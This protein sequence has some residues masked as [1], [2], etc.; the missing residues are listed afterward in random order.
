MSK[1]HSWL[2]LK[3]IGQANY[4]PVPDSERIGKHNPTVSSK[5][6]WEVLANRSHTLPIWSPNICLFSLPHKIFSSSNPVMAPNWE[7]RTTVHSWQPLYQ[8]LRCLTSERVM[9]THHT[10]HQS[11]APHAHMPSVQW[12]DR[13]RI[14]T[15]NTSLWKGEDGGTPW[16]LGVLRSFLDRCVE[17]LPP[18]SAGFPCVAPDLMGS[19]QWLPVHVF[20]VTLGRVF[21]LHFHPWPH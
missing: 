10:S 18:R 20:P 16:T 1:W 19:Q 8:V 12:S 5:G 4:M 9:L 14:V 2:P 15:I 6:E 11:P 17:S 3:S 7:L 13:E 21:F